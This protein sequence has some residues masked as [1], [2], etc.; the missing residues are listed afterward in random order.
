MLRSIH[1]ECSAVR[2]RSTVTPISLAN[3]APDDLNQIFR[4]PQARIAQAFDAG[5]YFGDQAT[6]LGKDDQSHS[7]DGG[8]V[9]ALSA[10]AGRRVIHHCYVSGMR[11]GVAENGG[12][13]R[14]QSPTPARAV[15]P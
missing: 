8:D 14:A 15:H 1:P 9:Q 7:T 11:Q 3:L 12:L 5:Y 13:S 10:T 6:P 4:Q 2:P